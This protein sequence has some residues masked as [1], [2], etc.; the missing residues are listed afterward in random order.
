MEAEGEVLFEL[1][2][3]G[4]DGLRVVAGAAFAPTAAD[5]DARSWLPA[6]IE[7]R[8]HPFS[9]TIETVY[10]PEEVA[11]WRNTP[12]MLCDG[13]SV[14][15]GDERAPEVHLARHGSNVEVSVTPNADDPQ[16]LLTFV[17]FDAEG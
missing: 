15:V 16:P 4:G 14:T 17:L 3:R 10:V 5:P 12:R 9:G 8:A 13:E 1:R 11:E 7:V 6:R 2:G